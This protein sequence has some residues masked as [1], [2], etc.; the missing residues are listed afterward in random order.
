[1]ELKIVPKLQYKQEAK[2]YQNL[3]MVTFQEPL[4]QKQSVKNKA[5]SYTQNDDI[6]TAT[7]QVILPI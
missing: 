2:H 4:Q 6:K 1:M 3:L 7:K 5:S